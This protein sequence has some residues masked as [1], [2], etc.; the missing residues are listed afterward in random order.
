ML[1]KPY[2][3]YWLIGFIT[4]GILFHF[5]G[6][7]QKVYWVDEAFTSLRI[8]GYG[9]SDLNALLA[10]G[11]QLTFQDL[12]HFQQP[13]PDHTFWD[14]LQGLAQFEPQLTPLYFLLAKG[15]MGLWGS[16]ITAIRLL[17]VVFSILSL[18]L[19]YL[20]S[21]ELFSSGLVALLSV[22]LFTTSPLQITY[23]QEARPYSLWVFFTLLSSWLL[24]RTLRSPS[25]L[26]W[27]GYGFATLFGWWTYLLAILVSL[28]QGAYS[29]MTGPLRWTA[30]TRTMGVVLL[31]SGLG[32]APWIW[33]LVHY[34]DRL[35]ELNQWATVSPPDG[36]LGRLFSLGS[37]V[38]RIFIDLEYRYPFDLSQPLPYGLLVLGYLMLVGSALLWLYRNQ[39]QAW[40]FLMMLGVPLWVVL[41][42]TDL[43]MGGQRSM[44]PR[45]LLPLALALQLAVAAFLGDRITLNSTRSRLWAILTIAILSLGLLSIQSNAPLPFSWSRQGGYIPYVSDVIN[46]TQ[47]P[48]VLADQDVWLLSLSHYL[49]PETPLWMIDS[50]N[51]PSP[52]PP[53]F[54]D[55]FLY[56]LPPDYLTALGTQY[57]YAIVPLE[58]LDQ[59]PLR[60]VKP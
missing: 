6:I 28:G 39:R 2:L 3:S 7:D 16:S 31:L 37:L 59:I 47:N 21:Q 25:R 52:L 18:P 56:S 19:V 22:A 50:S 26:A 57:N 60:V 9:E 33:V 44:V 51:P 29:W 15:W 23:A 30:T 27:L 45:Y 55:Y 20:L 12:R 42:M 35:G 53:G 36:F 38:T 11:R 46:K 34:S 41:T 5:M 10:P 48:L 24:L 1:K 49:K 32:F 40:L 14:T 43:I 54:S 17:S 58:G 13:N 4:V 8:S